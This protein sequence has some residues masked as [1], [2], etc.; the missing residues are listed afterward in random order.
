MFQVFSSSRRDSGGGIYRAGSSSLGLL[1]YFDMADL[2]SS[3][4]YIVSKSL[5]NPVFSDIIQ[6]FCLKRLPVLHCRF[7]LSPHF[8]GLCPE[9]WGLSENLWC[10]NSWTLSDPTLR[11]PKLSRNQRSFLIPS[12]QPPG[13]KCIKSCTYFF[14]KICFRWL[15]WVG[16]NYGDWINNS[17][18]HISLKAKIQIKNW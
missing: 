12:N 3:G 15:C 6:I 5:F 7:S 9:K 4:P 18:V 8:T 10:K 14:W 2:A 16:V 13:F 11:S 17:T 1:P